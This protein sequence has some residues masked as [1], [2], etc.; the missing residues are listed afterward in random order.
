MKETETKS[1]NDSTKE[2]QGNSTLNDQFTYSLFENSRN[3]ECS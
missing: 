2:Q 3:H 1:L